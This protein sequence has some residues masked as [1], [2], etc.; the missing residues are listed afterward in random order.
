MDIDLD[1][2]F[3]LIDELLH[4]DQVLVQRFF[5]QLGQEI[6]PWLVPGFLKVVAAQARVND[7]LITLRVAPTVDP[8]GNGPLWS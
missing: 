4:E 1:K 6:P 8:N 5:Q 2:L 7:V 3:D